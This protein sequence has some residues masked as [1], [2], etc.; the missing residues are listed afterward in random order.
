MIIFAGE[1][2]TPT[3][4]PD[5]TSQ[6]WQLSEHQIQTIKKSITSPV[7]RVI[8]SFE[9]EAE[10]FHVCQLA[11]L[12]DAMVPGKN[13]ILIADYLPY[14]R[15]DKQVSNTTTFALR[16]FVD[17][18]G[19][20]FQEIHSIDVHNQMAAALRYGFV[21][22]ISP[23]SLILD[24]IEQTKTDVYFYPDHSAFSRYTSM[25]PQKPFTWA[26]KNRDAMTGKVVGMRIG[27]NSEVDV[28]DKNILMVDDICDG[29]RTFIEAIKLVKDKQP[30]S[31]SLYTTHGI[32]SKGLDVL[33]ENGVDRVFNMNGEMH[34]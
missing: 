6:V 2:V 4:F 33:F 7:L 12:I 17:I 20:Y 24:V 21:K 26:I 14:A 31:I 15:Q 28:T 1:L 9:N 23:K 16:T 25:L 19:N 3:I 5:G 22:N 10:L 32:Y 27:G 8:W 18:L 34:P 29:G 11:T 13:I 30:K